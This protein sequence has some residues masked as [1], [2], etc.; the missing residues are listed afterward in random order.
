MKIVTVIP[1]KKGVWNEN[2][3]YFTSKDIQNGSIVTIP[4]RK[5][6]I[7]GMVIS[8][9][10]ASD[11]KK[12]IKDLSFNL[13]K[14]VDIKENT[15]FRKEYLEAALETSK[16][17]A[18]NKSNTFASLIPSV[19]IEK[20]EEINF[21]LPKNIPDTNTENETKSKIKAEKLLLQL[22]FYDRI[23]IYKTLIRENFALK[24]SIFIVLPTEKDLNV[25]TDS[26]SKG[27]EQFTFAIHGRTTTK[28]NLR[29]FELITTSAHPL[30]ILGTAPNLV[31]PRHDVGLIILEHESSSAYRTISTPNFDLRVFVELF[32]SKI[33]AKLIFG[34][35]LLRFETLAR[36]EIDNIH[37]MHPLSFRIDFEGELEITNGTKKEDKNFNVL[38]EKTIE[39]I[40]QNIMRGQNVFVF[41]LRK[42]LATMTT[43]R[44]CSTMIVC[45]TCGAPVVLYKSRDGEKRMLVCNKC[46][47]ELDADTHCENCGSWNLIPLGIGTDTVV[48]YL[49]N[50]LDEKIK[51]FKLDKESAK[52]AKGAELIIEEFE[53]T[54]GSILIGTEMAFFYMKNKVA[55]SVIASFD[56]LWSIPNFKM[57]EKILQ[58]TISILEKTDAK[59]IIQTKNE[60]D[61]ALK[62][63]QNSN[64]LSFY[65]E[66]IEE[67]KKLEYPPFKRFIK[68]THLS[69]KIKT[70]KAKEELAEIF[71]NY[72]PE[73]FSGFHTKLQ[74]K[75]VTNTLIKLNPK[76]WS[77]PA[78]TLNSNIDENLLAKLALLPSD[79]LVSVDPED[80]L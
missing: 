10:D 51:I 69:D 57:S 30:L 33:N 62:A 28:K 42:G 71:R 36:N 49:K 19:F 27:I 72:A 70:Q 75:Y 34:D 45:N 22:P 21:S 17:F 31:I 8:I 29:T 41:A 54:K 56:S 78:L 64:L 63:I 48:E 18:I 44:D 24:K 6:N 65:R 9:E 66:E 15:F 13:K 52:S 47:T 14:V 32:A 61:P 16:Y 23:S 58:I 59:L 74:D 46:K 3:T 39:E 67:R 68:I 2:L 50:I 20:Y 40:K 43:C 26:L 7:L 11:A 4:F 53:K 37:P 60:H 80:L 1:L 25:F 73:I 5:K 76:N 79:F 12:N 77:L 55:L 38:T 35:T